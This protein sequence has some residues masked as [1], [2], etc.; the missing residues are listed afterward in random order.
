M[1]LAGAAVI[2]F[3]GGVAC[4]VLA[5]LY[6]ANVAARMVPATALRSNV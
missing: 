6:P 5:A 3:L 4:A 2:C 1:E